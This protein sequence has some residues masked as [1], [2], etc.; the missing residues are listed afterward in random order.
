[1]RVEPMSRRRDCRDDGRAET[2]LASEPFG[3]LAL[4]RS[5][6]GVATAGVSGHMAAV[7]LLL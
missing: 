6:A 1:M 2:D 4:T 3:D 5:E 7:N